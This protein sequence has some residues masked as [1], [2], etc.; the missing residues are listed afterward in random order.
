MTSTIPRSFLTVDYS[1]RPAKQVERRFF[2]D[3]FQLLTEAGF[4]VRKYRYLGMGSIHFIDFLL[5]HKY[6]GVSDMISVELDD[7]IDKR[8]RFN[9]PYQ[10]LIKT[11]TGTKIGDEVAKID[12]DTRHLLWLDY[13]QV[14]TQFMIEDLAL[15]AG[16]LSSGSILLITVDTELPN[17]QPKYSESLGNEDI[18]KTRS[19]YENIAN[20]YLPYLIE[21]QDYSYEF[22]PKLNAGIF[23]SI[24]RSTISR[25]EN[26]DFIQLYNIV[27]KDGHRMLTYGGM[28][29]DREE[30]QRLISSDAFKAFYIKNSVENAYYIQI[31]KLTRKEQLYLESYVPITKGN[32]KYIDF[33]IGEE[34]LSR[35][36]EIYR[37]YPVYGEL[38]L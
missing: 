20:M 9:A 36:N 32:E 21:D 3:S 11:M 18:N 12:E 14:L 37:F 15:A 8:I 5:F 10:S 19:F 7:T 29:V 1:L 26:I 28:F 16:K 24:I 17:N 13:D 34:D 25:R 35:F 4:I 2:I 23:D 30:K 22:L 38:V 27:Y 31:P 6:F 33:E